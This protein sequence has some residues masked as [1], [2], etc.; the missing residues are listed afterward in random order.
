MISI[1]PRHVDVNVHPSKLEVKF[2]D[3][4]GIYNFVRAVVKHS[5]AKFNLIPEVEI[6]PTGEI[7]LRPS[8]NYGYIFCTGIN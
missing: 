1:N 7:K 2:D 4:Q 6:E 3:E 5:L 8:S